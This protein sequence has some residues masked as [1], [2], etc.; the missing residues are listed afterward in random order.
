VFG[1]PVLITNPSFTP[2]NTPLS[3]GTGKFTADTDNN[4]LIWATSNSTA[5]TVCS[6][7]DEFE[8]QPESPHPYPT[9]PMLN[10][11]PNSSGYV[12]GEYLYPNNSAPSCPETQYPD[13]VT[14]T[15]T[16][17]ANGAAVQT[18][19]VNWSSCDGPSP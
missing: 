3:I 10:L 12:N 14:L 2:S 6:L 9:A 1:G 11:P 7:M 4:A 8:N 19:T 16:D 15:C 13:T 18:V 5:N 17:A